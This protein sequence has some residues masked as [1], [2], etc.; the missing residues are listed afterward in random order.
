MMSSF[1]RSSSDTAIVVIPIRILEEKETERRKRDDEEERGRGRESARKRKGEKIEWQ[2][3]E[4]WPH[5]R[6]RVTTSG[7]ER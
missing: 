3:A 6:M 2:N 5:M 4:C 7:L 1:G